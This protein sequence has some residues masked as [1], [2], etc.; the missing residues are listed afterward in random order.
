MKAKVR[1]F[2]KELA[3]QMPVRKTGIAE[4]KQTSTGNRKYKGGSLHSAMMSTF[5]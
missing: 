2:L 3:E 1:K 4:F 5:N